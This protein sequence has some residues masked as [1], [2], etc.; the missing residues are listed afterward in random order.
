[1]KKLIISV[2]FLLSSTSQADF[3][4]AQELYDQKDYSN[5]FNE[6]KKL[7]KL[8]NVKSQY[9]VAVMLSKG[10]GVEK[11][12]IEAYA[13]AS[14]VSNIKSYKPLTSYIKEQLPPANISD[15]NTLF[16]KYHKL[17]AIENSKVI[18]GPLVEVDKNNNQ[19]AS[20]PEL[21]F[22]SRN[23]PIYPREMLQKHIQGWV[24]ILFY[25][26]PDGSVRDIQVVEQLPVDGAFHAA[27]IKSIESY[28]MHYE[29]DGIQIKLDQPRAITQRINFYIKNSTFEFTQKH[30]NYLN[31]LKINAEKGDLSSQYEYSVLQ[32]RFYINKEIDQKQINQWL[33]N[34][35]QEGI[36]DAQYRLGMNIFDGKACRIEKQKGLD[37][38]F[39]SAQIGNPYAQYTAYKMLTN[40]EVIN[41]TK[42]EPFYWLEQA[43]K[44]GL[45]IAQLNY[46]N[47]ISH[48][49]NPTKEELIL[50]KQ[51]IKNYAKETYKTVQWYQISALIEGKLNNNS[52]ALKKTKKALKLAK[53]YDWDLT[54]LEQQLAMF[55]TR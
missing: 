28:K 17:Y 41:R 44:N 22:D 2:L 19:I 46:A 48:K 23:P 49:H 52:K 54:E 20:T 6:F 4:D 43:A 12:L 10:E 31:N 51:Y 53:K 21:V 13:W 14:L 27:A 5:A 3:I 36:A 7:A 9:N 55:E 47:E 33:F 45:S 40:E 1:M 32:E 18:L 39:L 37:W 38:I 25:I 16:E 34:A 42:Q 26:Y 35:S 50:A 11:N 29:K 30:K 15:A 24:K 8:G